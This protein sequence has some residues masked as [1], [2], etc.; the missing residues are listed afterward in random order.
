MEPELACLSEAIAPFRTL[1]IDIS[2]Q[3]LVKLYRHIRED[4]RKRCRAQRE[5]ALQSTRRYTVTS[6]AVLLDLRSQ[7]LFR[8]RSILLPNVEGSRLAVSARPSE[9][10]T[11]TTFGPVS[12]TRT[13]P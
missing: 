3:L 11:T 2:G 6:Q 5:D 12:P 4:I 1:P 8:F 13:T 7:R 9:L 10:L